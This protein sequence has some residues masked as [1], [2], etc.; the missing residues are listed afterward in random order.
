MP[1]IINLTSLFLEYSAFVLCFCY[2]TF[3]S[4]VRSKGIPLLF[5]G[6]EIDTA[7]HGILVSFVLFFNSL[8]FSRLLIE[9]VLEI[10]SLRSRVL[11]L[12]TK[13]LLPA[14][15]FLL[16]IAIITG[17]RFDYASYKLQWNMIISGGNPWGYIEGGMVNAYGYVF[18]FL[19]VFLPASSLLPKLLFV[20]LLL[21]FCRRLVSGCL[22]NDKSLT[23]FLCINPFTV[24][25]L[26]VYGFIDGVCS[27]LLGLA[28]LET[29]KRCVGSS[30]RS[31]I[32]LSLSFL[33]KFYSI[34]A[35]PL[36]LSLRDKPR[37][38]RGFIKGFLAT[39]TLIVVFSYGL[40]GESIVSPLFFAKG[41][42]PS[43]LTLWRY[44]H[45]PE[46]RTFIFS[47]ISILTVIFASLRNTLS[48]S[49]RT[50]AVLSIIF[51]FYYLG[52]QQFYLGVLI[53][54]A[55]YINEIAQ[56][57][58]LRFK[59]WALRSFAFLFGWLIFIQS[60]F[61][62]FDEFK[63]IGLQGLE[64]FFSALNSTILIVFGIYWLVDKMT[65]NLRE[66][67]PEPINW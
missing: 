55:I 49:L 43:F 64:P 54:L 18:N 29:S 22:N 21:Y 34:A 61:E 52:H 27:L 65:Y 4:I 20:V 59:P 48:I 15:V 45:Y 35:L 16:L 63:P 9:L 36:F 14:C 7:L 26:A 6:I 25:T 1:R 24:S 37:L 40:W 47:L 11:R 58:T 41:R 60:G 62:L 19:A 50:A 67:R 66:P 53:P 17:G 44:V 39:S 42:D 31:G 23:I 56:D 28:L 3:Y 51:G 46:L 32:F 33:T 10:D 12:L 38:F 13:S 30:L 57:S 5:S 8:F 2:W